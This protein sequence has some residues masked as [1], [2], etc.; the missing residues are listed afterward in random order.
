M[1]AGMVVAG[2]KLAHCDGRTWHCLMNRYRMH[3]LV[4]FQ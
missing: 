1:L 4:S 2:V 3:N